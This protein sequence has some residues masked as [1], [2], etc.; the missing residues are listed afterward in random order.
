[1]EKVSVKMFEEALRKAT[2]KQWSIEKI[3]QRAK[4]TG[5]SLL[6]ARGF[7]GIVEHDECVIGRDSDRGRADTIM[8]FT[9]ELKGSVRVVKDLVENFTLEEEQF[10]HIIVTAGGVTTSKNDKMYSNVEHM[11]YSFLMFDITKHELVPRHEFVPF[12][13]AE[14]VVKTLHATKGQL[15]ILLSSDPV[16]IFCGF[17]KGDVVRIYRKSFGG[18]F[19]SSAAYRRVV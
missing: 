6:A 17:L 10:H 14:V 8:Y 9:S 15:P 3:I 19:S 11:S 13:E 1:M 18:F 7:L 16:A 5:K 2:T 4:E 12:D